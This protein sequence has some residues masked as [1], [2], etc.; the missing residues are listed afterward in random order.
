MSME[1]LKICIYIAYISWQ[2]ASGWL[3]ESHLDN[4][5]F[6]RVIDLIER[7][8]QST[9]QKDGPRGCSPGKGVWCT[10]LMAW[11]PSPEF[12]V[13]RKTRPHNVGHA[14]A[15]T[16]ILALALTAGMCTHMHT[17][18]HV[19]D[20][21]RMGRTGRGRKAMQTGEGG[22]SSRKCHEETP[23]IQDVAADTVACCLA[24]W[25]EL[26]PCKEITDS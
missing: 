1:Y 26:D 4:S 23:I 7:K 2:Q 19:W 13:R 12:T 18:I 5:V 6:R 22:M 11:L 24:W 9:R 25:P 8:E 17:S 15:V 14:C 16:C 20:I 21:R 10:N 3:R